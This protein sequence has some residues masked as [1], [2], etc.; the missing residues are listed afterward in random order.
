MR[1]KKNQ[2]WQATEADKYYQCKSPQA[3]KIFQQSCSTGYSHCIFQGSLVIRYRGSQS[4]HPRFICAPAQIKWKTCQM[5]YEC[6]RLN[7]KFIKPKEASSKT[8]CA[9][10]S[11]FV[12]GYLNIHIIQNQNTSCN[13][14]ATEIRHLQSRN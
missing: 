14:I 3:T 7:W 9:G 11:I 1:I 4:E 10:V 13:R 8:Q 6:T 12:S 2:F 5:N